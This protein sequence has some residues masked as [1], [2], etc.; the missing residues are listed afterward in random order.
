[1][2]PE[3]SARLARVEALAAQTARAVLEQQ[4]AAPRAAARP[5]TAY[6]PPLRWDG[7]LDTHRMLAE[8]LAAVEEIERDRQRKW[9]RNRARREAGMALYESVRARYLREIGAAPDGPMPSWLARQDRAA[10]NSLMTRPGAVIGAIPP[11]PSQT[12]TVIF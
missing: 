12:R 11:D 5:R 10:Y 7:K 9:D 4:H 2:T 3:E 6:E 1:M 8:G